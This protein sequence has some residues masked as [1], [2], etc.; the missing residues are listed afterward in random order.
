MANRKRLKDP[1]VPQ[2]LL[3]EAEAVG[4]QLDEMMENGEILSCCTDISALVNVLAERGLITKEEWV[5]RSMDM[6]KEIIAQVQEFEKSP[7][8]PADD[9]SERQH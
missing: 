9:S 3:D 4:K 8:Q 7:P 2:A 1:P 5:R 6:R